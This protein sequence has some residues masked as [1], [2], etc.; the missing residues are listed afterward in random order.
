MIKILNMKKIMLF[1]AMMLVSAITYAQTDYLMTGSATYT[2]CEGTFYDSGGANGNYPNDVVQIVTFC[3]D[4]DNAAIRVFFE[5]FDLAPGDYLEIYDGDEITLTNLIATYPDDLIEPGGL[6]LTHPA[7]GDNTTGCLT[8]RFVSNATG[9]AAGWKAQIECV[10]PCQ[11]IVASIQSSVPVIDDNN[12]IKACMGQPVHMVGSA[13]FSESSQGAI[14]TWD[15]GNGETLTGQTIN[16]IYNEP[17]IYITYLVVSDPRNCRNTNMVRTVIQVSGEPDVTSTIPDV[18]CYNEE[19][20][21]DVVGLFDEEEA[22]E[23][24][25]IECTPP[26]TGVTFLPDGD[27]TSYS[28]TLTLNCYAEDAVITDGSQLINICINIEHSYAGDL[29]IRLISPDG[30][31]VFLH[32]WG[33]PGFYLGQA[34]DLPGLDPGTGETYCFT[35]DASVILANGSTTTGGTPAGTMITPGDY[36]PVE[37]FDELIGSPINGTWT[38]EITD[39]WL[40]DN[41]YIF[42]WSMELDP[43]LLSEQFSFQPQLTEIDWSNEEMVVSSTNNGQT[44]TVRPDIFGE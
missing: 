13:V 11:S 25:T 22:F 37:D 39:Q 21:F 19:Y 18:M 3:P 38:L 35:M 14:Y 9:N 6:P 10:A 28:T 44:V 33:T 1:W 17:G 2:T 5:E 12:I 23:E 20:T 30:S 32:E 43:E 8:F 29:D 15:M 41:G 26:V 34:N 36:L 42:W 31:S 7:S 4:Q 16:Y 27:G 24:Y 40:A